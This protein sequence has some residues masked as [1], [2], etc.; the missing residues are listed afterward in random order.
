MI[1][2]ETTLEITTR[3]TEPETD[4]GGTLT[5]RHQSQAAPVPACVPH[6]TIMIHSVILLMLIC[7]SPL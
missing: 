1:G 5:L 3:L 2:P 6:L 7:E 4:T